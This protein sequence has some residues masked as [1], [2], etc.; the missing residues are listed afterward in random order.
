[1]ETRL[2]IGGEQVPG[3]GATLG[4]ENPTTEETVAEVGSAS[5]E[6]IDAAIERLHP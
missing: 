6:Q 2:L 3:E 5:P 4:V 1:M